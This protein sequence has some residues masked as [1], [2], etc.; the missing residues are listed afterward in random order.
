MRDRC[1][2]LSTIDRYNGQRA[3]GKLKSIM[4]PIHRRQEHREHDKHD[5]YP[6]RSGYRRNEISASGSHLRPASHGY[7]LNGAFL[8]YWPL[9]Q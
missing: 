5:C 6:E 4:R 8:M 1:R 3:S 7:H 9:L 2:V